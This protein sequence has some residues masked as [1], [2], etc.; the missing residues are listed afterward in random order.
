MWHSRT[1]FRLSWSRPRTCV[2]SYSAR[3][4]SISSHFGLN[5]SVGCGQGGTTTCDLLREWAPLFTFLLLGCALQCAVVQ[6]CSVERPIPKAANVLDCS[7]KM[8]HVLLAMSGRAF[9]RSHLHGGLRRLGS[10]T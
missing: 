6:A 4:V 2:L 1:V 5:Q 9:H 8:M 3:F 7:C 10:R